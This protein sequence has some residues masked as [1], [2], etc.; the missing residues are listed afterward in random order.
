MNP[1]GPHVSSLCA[2]SE[3][4]PTVSFYVSDLLPFRLLD[5]CRQPFEGLVWYLEEVVRDDRG[6]VNQ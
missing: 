3:D 5:K 6:L 2:S 4:C 1:H